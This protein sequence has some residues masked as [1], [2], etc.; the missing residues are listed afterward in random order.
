MKTK[1]FKITM[2]ALA[3][4]MA[5]MASFA[6][7]SNSVDMSS[8]PYISSTSDTS[9]ASE[10]F[11]VCVW[12]IDFLTGFCAKIIVDDTQIYNCYVFNPGPACTVS[13]LG[14][15]VDLYSSAPCT[16]FNL[17]RKPF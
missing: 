4:M 16:F 15:S 14:Q 10:D 6:Y 11:N 13:V 2:P 3:L 8:T 17:L 12:Y 7:T 5:I 9:Q 1:I